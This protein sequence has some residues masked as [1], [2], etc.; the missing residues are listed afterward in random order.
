MTIIVG[1]NAFHADSSACLVREGQLIAA[2]EEERFNRVKHWAGL[3]E[4]A[5]GYCM[6]EARVEVSQIDII[7]VN[8]DPRANLCRKILHTIRHRPDWSFL[9]D[10]L[11]SRQ[12]STG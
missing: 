4:L 10:R 8:T 9:K 11:R 1:I 7:A 3:P 12:T 5:V 6:K 2:A